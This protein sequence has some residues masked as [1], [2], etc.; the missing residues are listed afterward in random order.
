MAINRCPKCYKYFKVPADEWGD[1]A[2]PY[3]GYHP[4]NEEEK[5]IDKDQVIYMERVLEV[6]AED[7]KKLSAWEQKFMADIQERYTKY[8]D[9][10]SMSEKQWTIVDKIFNKLDAEL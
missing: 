6:V 8:G 4:E 10:I 5:M 3:C 1:H 7:R 2:C 9:R